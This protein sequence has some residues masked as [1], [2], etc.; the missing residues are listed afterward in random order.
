MSIRR[1]HWLV[2]FLVAVLAHGSLILLLWEPKESG[3]ANLGVGG[4][5]IS[6]GM[7]GGA[8]GATAVAPPEAKTVD[9]PEKDVV[10][11]VEPPPVETAEVME[12]LDAI[13][14]PEPIEVEA[15]EPPNAETVP[16]AEVKPKTEAAKVPTKPTP[17]KEVQPET[18]KPVEV[19]EPESKPEPVAPK[20]VAS[21]APPQ[22]Q[23]STQAP[24]VA[25]SAGKSGTKKSANVGS[26]DNASSGG[27]PGSA[28]SYFARLQA[29][30]EQHKEY[31]SSARRRRQE[32][33]AV[34]TFTMNRGGEVL[35]ARIQ[36]GT[37]YKALDEEVIKMIER[38]TPLPPLPDDF[39]Q[40][41][42][43]L[44]VPVQF[45]LY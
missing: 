32:G 11:P 34:L 45:Q 17:P 18:A 4:M 29:W 26:G 10:E 40:G 9:A 12:P 35:A 44:S 23:P 5:E 30:L 22:A 43:T 33:T 1:K 21:T 31:P 13:E 28:D 24:A 42:L 15:V 27:R 37:G 2:A 8:P 36:R 16:V 39:A 3:A 19:A 41:E 7:A 25:G 38:A 20:E 14:P 6:F